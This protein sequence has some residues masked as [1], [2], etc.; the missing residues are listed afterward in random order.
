V[1]DIRGVSYVKWKGTATGCMC[2]A[3]IYVVLI[4]WFSH[5]VF[6]I[7]LYLVANKC[8]FILREFDHQMSLRI[9]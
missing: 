4:Q 9:L 6:S 2:N 7:L 3:T 8:R 1:E 5:N